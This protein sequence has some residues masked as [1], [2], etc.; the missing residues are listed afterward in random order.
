LISVRG[1]G[2]SPSAFET[3]KTGVLNLGYGRPSR[4]GGATYENVKI[5]SAQPEQ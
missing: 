5:Y 3:F 1:I 4:P 2:V